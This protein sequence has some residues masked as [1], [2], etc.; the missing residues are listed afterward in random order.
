MMP[1]V[2]QIKQLWP[3]LRWF[4]SEVDVKAGGSRNGEKGEGKYCLGLWVFVFVGFENEFHKWRGIFSFF[5]NNLN[6]LGNIL[7][8]DLPHNHW[9]ML[10]VG[11]YFPNQINKGIKLSHFIIEGSKGQSK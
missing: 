10:Q 7:L 11:P 1:K 5:I 8:F 6:L 2:K 4:A 9:Q 3:E